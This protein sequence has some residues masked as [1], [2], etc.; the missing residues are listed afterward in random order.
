[1]IDAKWNSSTYIGSSLE[2]FKEVDSYLKT[3]P[4]RILDIGCGFAHISRA[5]QQKYG[6][7][8]WLLDG[9]FNNNP[10]TANRKAKYG[11]ANDFQFYMP[12]SMLREH[13]DQTGTVY[14]F[15]D[16]NNINIPED[17]KFDFVCSWLSCGFHYPAATYKD[18]ILKHTTD[19][20]TIIMDFRRK[21]L[22]QQFKDIDVVQRLNGEGVRKKYRMH[23]KF[24]T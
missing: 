22:D 6:T 9:D 7:E 2:I 13:L 18:L 16:A 19:E 4:K 14:N 12:I 20:S 10:Q 17:I 24:K 23:I 8:L 15:V 5:F 21:S 1:M 11:A 3:P